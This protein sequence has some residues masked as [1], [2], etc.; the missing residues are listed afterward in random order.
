MTDL[1]SCKL[2]TIAHLQLLCRAF[3]LGHLP[4]SLLEHMQD[5]C[6]VM[7][8]LSSKC[9]HPALEQLTCGGQTRPIGMPLNLAHRSPMVQWGYPGHQW[10]CVYL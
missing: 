1:K 8:S 3:C 7:L 6:S 10:E 4:Q 2:Q 9:P 5:V